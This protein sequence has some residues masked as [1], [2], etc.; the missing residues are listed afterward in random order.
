MFTVLWLEQR[1]TNLRTNSE[2]VL[3]VQ[4]SVRLIDSME[5]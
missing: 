3:I 2:N 5:P 4:G 1:F